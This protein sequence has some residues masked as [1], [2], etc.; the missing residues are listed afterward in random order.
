[1]SGSDLYSAIK[2]MVNNKSPGN[3][4]LTKAFYETCLDK[5]IDLLYKSVK[6]AKTKIQQ[7]Q[8][9]NKTNREFHEKNLS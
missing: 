1:M 8:Q 4:G 2:S 9:Q 7:Q 6:Y 5:I 3:D